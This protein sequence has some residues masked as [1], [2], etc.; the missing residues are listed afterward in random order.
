MGKGTAN[1]V[2]NLNINSLNND[3]NDEKTWNIV[4]NG[5]TDSD[6]A[7][8]EGAQ[9]KAVF[10]VVLC[11]IC[12]RKMMQCN[13]NRQYKKHGAKNGDRVKQLQYNQLTEDWDVYIKQANNRKTKQLIQKSIPKHDLP[14]IWEKKEEKHNAME[15]FIKILYS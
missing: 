9:N 13:F 1:F 4:Y 15:M 6:V 11:C 3:Y 12:D 10:K 8:W 5:W 2:G 14:A 7:T